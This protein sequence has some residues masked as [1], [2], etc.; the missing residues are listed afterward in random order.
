MC[1]GQL[2]SVRL[3][4]IKDTN[5]ISNVLL[6]SLQMHTSKKKVFVWT[7][8]QKEH[9]KI[10]IKKNPFFSSEKRF[11]LDGFYKQQNDRIR[12][13]SRDQADA[14]GEIHRKTKF[15]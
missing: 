7:L 5:L 10:I 2:C 12:A 4:L 6:P 3:K 8:G 11:D 15:P 9:K 1:H 13:P 14:N